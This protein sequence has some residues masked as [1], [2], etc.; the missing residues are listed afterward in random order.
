MQA[1]TAAALALPGLTHSTAHAAQGEEFSFQYGHYQEGGGPQSN[2]RDT[3]NSIQVDSL[4]TTGSTRLFDRMKL[5][6]NYAQ[7]TW[8][9]ATPISTAPASAVQRQDTI[10]GASPF[11]DVP[12][13]ASF[14][15]KQGRGSFLD[16]ATGQTFTTD[17]TV[18]VMAYAS[19]EVRKQGDL[20]L[21][22]EWDEAALNLGGGVSVER[23]YNSSFVNAGGRWDLNQKL[24]TLNLGLS[25]T[26]SDVHANRFPFEVVG[27]SA[28]NPATVQGHRQDVTT[29]LALTQV[30]DKDSL[31]EASLGFTHSTGYLSNPYKESLFF[32][33]LD[34]PDLL[35]PDPDTGLLSSLAVSKL[36]NRPRLRDQWSWNT[37]YIHYF[38]G[39]DASLHFDYRFYHDSWGINAHTFEATWGQSIGQGWTV[40]PMVRYYSQSAA[41]F[42]SPYFVLDQTLSFDDYVNI[43]INGDTSILNFPSHYSSDYRLSGYGA[44]SGGVTISKKFAKGVTLEAGFQ[45]Y[46]HQ[47]G[48]KL[49]GGGTGN[50]QDFNYY[51]VNGAIRV[52]LDAASAGDSGHDAHAGHVGHADSSAPAGVMF[53]HMMDRPGE[54]MVGYR[55]MYSHQAGDMMH[56][57][58]PAGDAEVV[59]NGCGQRGCSFT[60]KAM[61]MHMHMLDLMY[62]PTNWLNLMLMPQFMDMNMTLRPLEG[63]VPNTE[64]GHQHGGTGGNVQHATGGVGDTGMYALVK[65]FGASGQHLHLG[66]GFTAPTGDVNVKMSGGNFFHYGMQLGSGT[67]DFRPSLTYTGQLDKWS[68]GGQISGIKRLEDQN[69]SGFAFGDVFQS[70]VW[71]S[72]RVFDWLSASVRGVYT[73]EGKVRG[74]F[75]GPHDQSGP[76]DFPANYGGQFW[77]IGFG[78]NASV[79]SGELKGNRL[80]VEWLQPVAT[81]FNGYQVDRDGGLFAT[82]SLAF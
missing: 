22:Y 74:E 36:D 64:G 59:A 43:V 68:W 57:S 21:G 77:D 63:G 37:R 13:L 27:S 25:Y 29:G 31:L 55:Y 60:P 80:G 52:D 44:L 61:N 69:D 50:F 71:G 19:P 10:V 65:L 15:P 3:G 58:N 66:L 73:S 20:S 82:W 7:D 1:L 14:D 51:L 72:Y 45:Y 75:N 17:E 38:T 8:S 54:F 41:D 32:A 67:W 81:D 56:G 35:S 40:T 78:L 46:T 5:L 48:L 53:S 28:P 24:T 42:Y 79:T 47:S 49:G 62:A 76:M 34:A 70:T 18:Q 23:D 4:Q 11:W 33:A 16:P 2:F 26:D 30:L 6:F 9:G 39:L 12:R